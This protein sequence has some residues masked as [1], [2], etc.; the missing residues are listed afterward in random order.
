MKNEK[1]L[2]EILESL[3]AKYNRR[4]LIAPDPL[5]FV[6]KFKSRS[7]KEIVALLA[8]SLAYGNVKQ[9][10]SSITNL[11]NIM[12]PSPTEFVTSFNAAKRKKLASFKH[13]FNTG[14]DI[15][16]LLALLKLILKSLN[17]IEAFFAEGYN[18]NDENIIPA[19]TSLCSRLYALHEK[20]FKR[21]PSKGLQYLLV[22][23][24][25][26]SVC[27]RMNMFLRWMVRSDDVDPGIWKSID[28]NKLIVPIDTHMAR[29]CK[30]LG[31]YDRKTLSLKAAIEITQS[32]KQINPADPVKY[33]FALSRIGI[34][35]N[36]TGKKNKY[37][38]TCELK[39]FCNS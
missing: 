14:A 9:I 33:D 6:Y 11:L 29:L 10:A 34:V 19:L 38:T 8:S 16:D 20:Q 22:T 27:K 26:G 17:S 39:I 4:Q 37:C 24:A 30:I 35:E 7:D 3:Y 1:Q 2:F 25:N 15:A 21:P 36:C 13:R 12:G 23:P 28:A 32:F 31:L 18:R 5:Q